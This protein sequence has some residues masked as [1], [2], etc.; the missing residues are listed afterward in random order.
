MIKRIG[1]CDHVVGHPSLYGRMIET[2]DHGREQLWMQPDREPDQ[3][4]DHGMQSGVDEVITIGVEVTECLQLP[5]FSSDSFG[6]L[7]LLA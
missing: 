5:S 4:L 2:F 1:R 3:V 7:G 6:I